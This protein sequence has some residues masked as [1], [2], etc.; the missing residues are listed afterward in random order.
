MYGEKDFPFPPL[1]LRLTPFFPHHIPLEVPAGA[2][3]KEGGINSTPF[4]P[5]HSSKV[6]YPL[7]LSSGGS[8]LKWDRVKVSLL[9]EDCSSFP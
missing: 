9:K 6:I 1:L 4:H 7:R 2:T 8:L 5:K 3:G